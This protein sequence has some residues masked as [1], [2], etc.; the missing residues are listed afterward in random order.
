MSKTRDG[1]TVSSTDTVYTLSP[2]GELETLYVEDDLI[3]ASTTFASERSGASH[4]RSTVASCFH[5]K[6]TVLSHIITLIE[7][8]EGFMVEPPLTGDE[9]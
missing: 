5:S 2:W 1:H 3:H 7:D 6:E 8:E 4:L 9:A